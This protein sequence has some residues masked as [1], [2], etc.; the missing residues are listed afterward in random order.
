MCPGDLVAFAVALLS[1]GGQQDDATVLGEPV[2]DPSCRRAE[3]ARSSNSPSPR[4]FE[5][6]IR[7]D[8]P[9]VAS[10]SI[11]T[12]V[13]S[14]SVSSREAIQSTISS[15]SSSSAT[16]RHYRIN[17]MIVQERSSH[18]DGR[19]GTGVDWFA[20]H[21][22]DAD[23]AL[24]EAVEGFAGDEAFEC[25]D[26]ERQLALGEGSLLAEAAAARQARPLPLRDVH[27]RAA[28]GDRLPAPR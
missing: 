17:A 9:S 25:F 14:H 28:P 7:A 24:V 22:E 16:H 19:S 8:E 13:R 15:W 18:G 5:S 12:T 6:G 23:D 4:L 10:R 21:G 3:R 27:R 26:A 11:T 1:E 20:L 2:G